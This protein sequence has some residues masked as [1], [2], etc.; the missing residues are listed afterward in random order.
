MCEGRSPQVLCIPRCLAGGGGFAHVMASSSATT[1]SHMQQLS[2]DNNA[3]LSCRSTRFGTMSD[4]PFLPD[5]SASS[6]FTDAPGITAQSTSTTE[7]GLRKSLTRAMS[8]MPATATG[9]QH[10]V[11][12][13]KRPPF[14]F[15][16][17]TLTESEPELSESPDSESD[18]LLLSLLSS[19]SLLSLESE[20]LSLLLLLLSLSLEL[21]SESLLSS[22]LLE[23]ESESELLLLLLSESEL[24]LLSESVDDAA[25]ALRFCFFLFFPSSLLTVSEPLF[26]VASFSRSS[27]SRS[28]GSRY[29]RVC[30][31]IGGYHDAGLQG[32][33]RSVGGSGAKLGRSP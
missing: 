23:L 5:P 28:L 9:L 21:V 17:L 10:N 26:W 22:E 14:L 2:D 29:R 15:A 16:F 3:H 13:A 6:S 32:K 1:G 30:Q 7:F 19:E 8:R 31:H 4:R 18:E 33:I 27:G 11:L 24:E 12:A 25:S 20:S